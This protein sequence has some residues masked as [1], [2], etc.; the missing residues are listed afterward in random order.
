MAQQLSHEPASILRQLDL[1]HHTI[2]F[3]DDGSINLLAN[4]EHAP[5]LADNG[6][7]LDRDE[8]YHLFISL[9]EAFKSHCFN[10]LTLSQKNALR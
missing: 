7:R 2:V 9:H 3:M 5:Y 1:G 10:Y 4:D 6:I 8:T